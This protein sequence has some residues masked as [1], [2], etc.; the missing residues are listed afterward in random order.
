MIERSI[1]KLEFICKTVPALLRS[2]DEPS[3]SAKPAPEKWSK[4]QITGH[5]IDSATNNHHRIVKGQFETMPRVTY[6]NHV[7]NNGNHYDEL[8]SEQVI[9]FWEAYNNFLLEVIKRIPE[10]KMA[11]KVQTG[12]AGEKNIMTIAFV[13]EDYVDHLEYHL[14]QLVPALQTK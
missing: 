4:K 7:W 5:L 14:K 2:I 1:Q 8:S 10:E 12:E 3:F 13:I 6:E 11:N 9:S